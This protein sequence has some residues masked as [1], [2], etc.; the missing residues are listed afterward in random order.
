MPYPPPQVA[1][2]GTV[3]I[4][5]QEFLSLLPYGHVSLAAALAGLQS[6]GSMLHSSSTSAEAKAKETTAADI[7]RQMPKLNSLRSVSEAWALYDKGLSDG[8]ALKDK[9][10][11]GPG[12]RRRHKTA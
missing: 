12:W 6:S 4:S 8:V 11:Q 3:I 7:C 2:G 9:E 5:V 10:A 1:P